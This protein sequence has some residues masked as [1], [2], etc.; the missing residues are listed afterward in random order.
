MNHPNPNLPGGRPHLPVSGRQGADLAFVWLH[1]IVLL[2]I[3]PVW[4]GYSMHQLGTLAGWAGLVVSAAVGVWLVVRLH[5]RLAV[6]D[7]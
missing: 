6:Q 2:V 7:W 5:D 1:A 3:V 4:M